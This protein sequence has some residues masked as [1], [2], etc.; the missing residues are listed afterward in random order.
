MAS[1]AAEIAVVAV[2]AGYT[3]EGIAEDN[4]AAAEESGIPS[5]V[6]AVSLLD[7]PGLKEKEVDLFLRDILERR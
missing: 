2:A 5:T 6:V 1:V 7:I 3:A 4:L